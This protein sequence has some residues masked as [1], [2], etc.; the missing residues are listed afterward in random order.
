MILV[1]ETLGPHRKCWLILN[2]YFSV[3]NM[4]WLNY[5]PKPQCRCLWKI[6]RM[7]MAKEFDAFPIC[8]AVGPWGNLQPLIVSSDVCSVMWGG[9]WTGQ[10]EL[11]SS[12]TQA[13]HLFSNKLNH[14]TNQCNCFVCA[15]PTA[16][17]RDGRCPPLLAA[18]PLQTYQKWWAV[19]PEP[20][21][22]FK[23]AWLLSQVLHSHRKTCYSPTQ[24]TAF[25]SLIN[26]S[27][28]ADWWECCN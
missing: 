28:S 8:G 26:R 27:V 25:V 1:S 20:I 12:N 4:T 3:I 19:T 17:G 6:C 5:S 13:W 11:I 2:S 14:A 10:I 24:W 21:Q 18:L 22:S 9:R 15:C 23:L 7:I 16:C